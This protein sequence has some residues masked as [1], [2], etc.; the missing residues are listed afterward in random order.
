MYPLIILP[1]KLRQLK[2]YLNPAENHFDML[3]NNVGDPDHL[4]VGIIRNAVL[5]FLT[6]LQYQSTQIVGNSLFSEAL[7]A[8]NL[9]RETSA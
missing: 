5:A 3:K 7:K 9:L 1:N 6:S 2:Y 4:L 8:N